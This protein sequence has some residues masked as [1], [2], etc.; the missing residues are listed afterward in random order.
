M[1]KIL[2]LIFLQLTIIFVVTPVLLEAETLSSIKDLKP[3]TKFFKYFFSREQSS[4]LYK[5]GVFGDKKLG[6]Q[7]GCKSQ[8][9]VKPKGFAILAPINFPEDKSHPIEGAWKHSFKFERCG[10]MKIYNA[11]FVAKKGAT[12]EVKPYFPGETIASPQLI[13]DAMKGAVLAASVK[14]KKDKNAPECKELIISDM[15]VTETPH[16]VVESDKTIS[17]AW[18]ENWTF[19]GCGR[20]INVLMD[21]VPDGKGGTIYSTKNN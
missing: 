10:E 6:L 16:N 12:L 13:S 2:G 8:Y 18:Q 14:I 7:Q 4:D 21:F 15:K 17:G 11:I 5:V 3:G 19:W 1:N 9:Q 20:S